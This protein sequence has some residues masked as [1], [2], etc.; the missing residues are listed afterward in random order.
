MNTHF[1]Y[2]DGQGNIIDEQGNEAMDIEEEIDPYN[3]A[4]LMTLAQYRSFQEQ[5]HTEPREDLDARMEEA[6]QELATETAKGRKYNVYT[7]KHKA[8]FWYFNRIKLWK[9]APSARKAQVEIRTAQK[10]AKRLKE[11]PDWNIYEK[12]ANKA[13][14]KQ[15]QLQHEHKQHLIEFFDEYP[16]ATR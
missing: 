2:E 12:Q 15:S 11:D 9:A 6:S 3:L 13:N 7:D 1:F 14:R 4:T 8:V 5:F 10:W 16:Q